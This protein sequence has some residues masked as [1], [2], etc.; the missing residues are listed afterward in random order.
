MIEEEVILTNEQ[1]E[2]VNDICNFYIYNT[3][4]Y[5]VYSGAAGTGKT[6]VIKEVI[7]ALN[8]ESYEVAC[9]AYVG[10]AAMVLASKGLPAK[11]IHSTI[12]YPYKKKKRFQYD[13]DLYDETEN[14]YEF[15]F[16]L[17]EHLDPKIKLIIVDEYSMVSDDLVSDILSFQI[18]TIFCGDSNQLEPVF[19]KST[20]LKKPDFVLT[21]I[22]RQ[23]EGNPIIDLSQ[24]ILRGERLK[25]GKYG[26][27]NVIDKID[28]DINLLKN[29]DII[30]TPTNN[31]RDEFN[32]YIRKNI[33]KLDKLY[34]PHIGE[35]VICKKNNWD[36]CLNGYYLVN[37][38]TGYI[39]DIDFY[40][41]KY[42]KIDFKPSFLRRSFDDLKIELGYINA[43]SQQ[44]KTWG[45]NK[46]D[47]FEYAYA[48]N[49]HVS[50]GSQYGRVLFIDEPFGNNE[51]TRQKIR[52]TAI[53][54][55]VNK[56]DI[57]I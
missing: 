5:Y 47:K 25:I 4:N 30:L 16:I 44:R 55:A 18:P 2:L 12:Y 52:Y 29:Y 39:M 28:M 35:K 50:Q 20:I 32:N 21:Q 22:M 48:I 51:L 1:K 36:R 13:D 38:M 45:F 49:V 23:A 17:K 37:G 9:L 15:G 57:V 42:A 54:R 33:L 3:K 53:T 34:V 14:N 27:S 41:D 40:K 10:K 43:T 19:G 46:Y 24:Q 7:K 8:L 56:I 31:T 11:T 26:D 6:T